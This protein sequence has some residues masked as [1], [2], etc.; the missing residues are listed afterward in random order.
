VLLGYRLEAIAAGNKINRAAAYQ[1]IKRAIIRLH[2]A[3]GAKGGRETIPAR[4]PA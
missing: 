4:T 2:A 3:N 1:R